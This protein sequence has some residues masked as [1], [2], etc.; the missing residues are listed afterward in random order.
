M[1]YLAHSW[2]YIIFL[3]SLFHVSCTEVFAI[4]HDSSL[5]FAESHKATVYMYTYAAGLWLTFR[6]ELAVGTRVG[7]TRAF[8]AAQPEKQF[9]CCRRHFGSVMIFQ[10]QLVG[11]QR[12]DRWIFFSIAVFGV[13]TMTRDYISSM[14]QVHGSDTIRVATLAFATIAS[15]FR[16]L[17]LLRLKKTVGPLLTTILKM[18]VSLPRHDVVSPVSCRGSLVAQT[19]LN[20]LNVLLL[21]RPM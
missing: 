10:S 15:W 8:K 4:Y 3:Y 14:Q 18:V 6:L 19:P 1:K 2:F 9:S 12:L 21:H 20:A 17:E 5:Y 7:G 11:I 16:S 13:L